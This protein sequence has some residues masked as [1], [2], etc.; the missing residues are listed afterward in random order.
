MGVLRSAGRLTAARLLPLTLL[1]ALMAVH[2]SAQAP[3]PF[4]SLSEA[5]GRAMA[6]N[7]RVLSSRESITQ[8]RLGVTLAEAAFGTKI[9][10]N[11]V[12]SFGQSDVRNQ[13]YGVGASRRFA[14]GTEVRMDVGAATFRNQ[15]G[16]FYAADTTLL[17]SQS[18]LRGFG[19]TVGRRPVERANYQVE[20][21][22]R[23]NELTE[24]QLGIEVA[25]VYYGLIAQRELA[26]AARTALENAERLLEAS[27]AKLQA[28]LVSQLDVFRARQLVAEAA[29]QLFDVEGSVEDLKDEMRFLIAQDA[30]YD[31]RVAEAID[32]RPDRVATQEAV[33]LALGNRIELR[34][35][36]AAV[37]EAERGVRF[38]RHEML[39]QFD[40]SL[41][42]TRRQTAE[43][44]REAFGRDRFEPVTFFSV[45]TPLDRT[46]ESAALQNAVI[47]RNRR[48]RDRDALRRRIAQEARRAV[49]QQQRLS[50]RLQTA[51]VSVEFAEREVDLATLRFQRGLTNNLDVVNA[52]AN[53]LNATSRRLAVLADLAVAR[54]EL[55]A[56]LGTLDV[57]RNVR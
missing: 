3:L 18:L 24:Q 16:N 57:R 46:A 47:E 56:T 14:T 1:Y 4:L 30:D 52:Q 12:G 54:L 31:F 49:R 27:E 55:Q 17:V 26:V 48:T 5:V 13:T 2:A 19:P 41:A 7:E 51:Q 36:E 25:R 50:N 10:P 37:D 39:P 20:S 43:S 15:L 9:T 38:A 33:E 53:Q 23:Q 28:N 6:N 35:A 45:S 44:L 8:A 42:L 11:V 32:A 40:V 29:G 21:A 34:D 22:R